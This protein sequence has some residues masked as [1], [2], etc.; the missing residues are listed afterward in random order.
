MSIEQQTPTPSAQVTVGREWTGTASMVLGMVAV[1][2]FG[3]PW[4]PGSVPSQLRYL[5]LYLTV[6]LGICAIV[7]GIG[8]LHHLRGEAGADRRRARAGV[9][10]GLVAVAVPP[11]LVVWACVALS[12]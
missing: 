5:P 9:A 7:H 1:A 4:L 11:A 2:L 8:D 12:E 6:P 10:L 3:C